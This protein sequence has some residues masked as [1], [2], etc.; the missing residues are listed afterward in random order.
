MTATLAVSKQKYFMVIMQCRLEA[1]QL[2]HKCSIAEK[3]LLPEETFIT[4][5][6]NSFFGRAQVTYR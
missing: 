6:V 5:L 3:A 1:S 4:A 2:L